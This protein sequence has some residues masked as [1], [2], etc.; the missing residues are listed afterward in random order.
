MQDDAMSGRF[1]VR[2]GVTARPAG[3]PAPERR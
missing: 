3:M 2:N 1:F